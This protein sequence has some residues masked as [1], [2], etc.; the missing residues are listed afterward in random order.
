[1]SLPD[2]EGVSEVWQLV[3]PDMFSLISIPF[4]G[5]TV[6]VGVSNYHV[7]YCCSSCDFRMNQYMRFL[8]HIRKSLKEGKSESVSILHVCT[9]IN[10]NDIIRSKC[11]EHH[12]A[13]AMS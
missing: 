4:Q 13:L 5:K 10:S 6:K 3:P 12:Y 8:L 7:M 2:Y 9:Y 11:V 1:M